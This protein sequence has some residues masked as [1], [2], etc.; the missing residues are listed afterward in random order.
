MVKTVWHG[1]VGGLSLSWGVLGDCPLLDI[2]TDLWQDNGESSE[3]AEVHCSFPFRR[4]ECSKSCSSLVFFRSIHQEWLPT[5]QSGWGRNPPQNASNIHYCC[6]AT[7]FSIMWVV[8]ACHLFDLNSA[9]QQQPC[10][11]S[12]TMARNLCSLVNI[13]LLFTYFTVIIC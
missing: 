12:L 10:I 8:D 5:R 4:G 13:Q 3:E 7:V 6:W 2:V 9:I 1:D 11:I